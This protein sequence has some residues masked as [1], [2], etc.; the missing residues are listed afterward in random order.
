M[1]SQRKPSLFTFFRS[2]PMPCPYLRGKVE[3]QLFTDLSGLGAQSRYE[4]L[5][6]GGFRRSHHIA[7]RPACRGCAACIPVRVVAPEFKPSRNWRRVLNKNA[8]LT[9]DDKGTFVS[10]EQFELFSRYMQSRHDGGDMARMDRND[11]FE[12]VVSSPVET[13]ILEYRN[14]EGT[15]V[16]ACLTDRVADGFS[17]VYSFFD[18]TLVDRSLGSYV[19]L[20]LIERACAE[21]LPYVYLGFWVADSSKMHYKIRFRPIEGFG[22]NGWCPLPEAAVLPADNGPV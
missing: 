5:S 8:D 13:S 18:P 4:I 6:Q 17:A 7:Y 15:L 1:T 9:V 14:P 10:N 19:V 21:K 11:Y 3:Q 16:A 22:P 20:S 2:G 12:M